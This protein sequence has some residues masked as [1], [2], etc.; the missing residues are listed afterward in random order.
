M[1]K[2]AAASAASLADDPVNDQLPG[3]GH[4]ARAAREAQF[5]ESLRHFLRGL[6]EAPSAE[7]STVLASFLRQA[8]SL[9]SA[10]SI[11]DA[12]LRPVARWLG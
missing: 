8:D 2:R 1:S 12:F 5:A 6:P 4:R 7:E 9:A 11:T 10:K 3:A